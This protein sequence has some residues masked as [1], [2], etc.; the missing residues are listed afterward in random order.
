MK[1]CAESLANDS[2]HYLQKLLFFIKYNL[3][4]KLGLNISNKKLDFLLFQVPQ[5][6][7]LL[8]SA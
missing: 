7:L 5:C 2:F 4:F 1:N 3:I 6:L 8:T